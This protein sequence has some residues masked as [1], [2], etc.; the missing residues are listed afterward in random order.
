M[1]LLGILFAACCQDPAPAVRPAPT[2]LDVV[3]LK[4]G[5]VLHGRVV[6]AIDGFVEIEVEAGARVGF[7]S[8]QVAAIRRGA[9]VAPSV[10]TLV[11][12]RREWFVLHDATGAAVGWLAT[13]VAHRPDGG[14]AVH[15]EYE[16]HDRDRR[17]QVTALATADAG[18]AASTA[19]FRERITE[20]TLGGVGLP[21]G[22][23][24]GQQDRVVDERI[25]EAEA[26][27]ESLVVTRVDRHGRRERALPW[28]AT[29]SF[30][31][32]ARTLARARRDVVADAALFDPAGEEIVARSYDGRRLRSVALGGKV[33]QVTEVTEHGRAGG[34]L[35]NHEWVDANARTLRR[36][37]AGPALVAVAAD[38]DAARNPVAA[39][40]APAIVAEAGEGFGAWI[41]NPAWI[42]TP[43]LPAGSLALQCE[44]HGA[45]ATL[46][47][48]DHLEPGASRDVAVDAVANAFRLMHP[49]AAVAERRTGRLRDRDT[50]RL[51]LRFRR[52]KEPMRAV[53]DVTAHGDQ[54]L[55]L[56][57]VAPDSAWDELAADFDFVR[58]NVEFA[59]QALRPTMQGPLAKPTKAAGKPPQ[60][61]AKPTAADRPLAA[62]MG[63]TAPRPATVR[64]PNGG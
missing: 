1:T 15:E 49:G 50:A 24:S 21:G 57:C 2:T 48:I 45:S 39:A 62:P 58:R 46:T 51:V 30:P 36:E 29:H 40:A 56:A 63:E 4:N 59:P 26:R 8:A 3:E 38:A 33:V 10:Q 47:R 6:V 13:A 12:P 60:A 28:A 44:V 19:Y 55:V 9:A 35:R 27:G 16:F 52:G 25:V 41:P 7:S 61:A 31:L 32:L 54:H 5:D 43:E 14:F 53:L 18:G 23:V 11:A 64:I 42:A 22:D 20:P 37:L 34:S 17:Y